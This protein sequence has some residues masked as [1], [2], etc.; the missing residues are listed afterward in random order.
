MKLQ[1]SPLL[2]NLHVNLMPIEEDFSNEHHPWWH[3]PIPAK[4]K[5][6]GQ[7]RVVRVS[8]NTNNDGIFYARF[9]RLG[10]FGITFIDQKSAENWLGKKIQVSEHLGRKVVSFEKVTVRH[11]GFCSDCRRNFT[12]GES[13]EITVS[14][15]QDDVGDTLIIPYKSPQICPDCD[16]EATVCLISV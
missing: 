6:S 16:G 15:P 3:Y 13:F 11:G 5:P 10:A 14:R 12:F 9:H 8:Y 1:P 2:G 7:T 4:Y